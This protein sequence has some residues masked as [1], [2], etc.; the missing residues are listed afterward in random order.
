LTNRQLAYQAAMFATNKV[1]GLTLADYL[2]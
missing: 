2:R 1:M